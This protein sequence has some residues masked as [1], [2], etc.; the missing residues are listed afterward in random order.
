[1]F[2]KIPVYV[3]HSN[4]LLF[5]MREYFS[6]TSSSVSY[7]LQTDIEKKNI[8]QVYDTYLQLSEEIWVKTGVYSE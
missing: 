8:E 2:E 4:K 5:I 7:E 3:S 1:M 6:V